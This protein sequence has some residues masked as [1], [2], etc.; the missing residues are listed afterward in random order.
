[1][2]MTQQFR[3][4]GFMARIL[5]SMP[6]RQP[7]LWTDEDVDPAT[8]QAYGDLL[9]LL[10][11]IPVRPQPVTVP[12]TPAAKATGVQ[13]YNSWN[14]GTASA[15][16]DLGSAFA[17][18]EAYAA[19]FALIHQVASAARDVAPLA[20]GEESMAAGI[21]L[22]RWFGREAE[23]V[24]AVLEQTGGDAEAADLLKFI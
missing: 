1:Q 8:T 19:R 16:G 7:K 13:F 18:I 20:V 17:K 10:R 22:A 11:S 12:L 24:Y 6:P 21:A 23:R 5:V 15:S 2:L 14:R 9:R 3:A 4:S